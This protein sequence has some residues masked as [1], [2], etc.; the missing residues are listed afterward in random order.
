VYCSPACAILADEAAGNVALG[1]VI[2]TNCESGCQDSRRI[3]FSEDGLPFCGQECAARYPKMVNSPEIRR[4]L[5][6]AA[7]GMLLAASIALMAIAGG[8]SALKHP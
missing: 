8:L 1:E 5:F 3:V 7:T 2:C 4:V 6:T